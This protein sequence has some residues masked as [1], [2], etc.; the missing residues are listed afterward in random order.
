MFR[1]ILCPSLGAQDFDLEHVVYC[2]QIVVGRR[3]GVQ[4]CRLQIL[5]HML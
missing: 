4:R 1:K 2:P 3:P 5:Y